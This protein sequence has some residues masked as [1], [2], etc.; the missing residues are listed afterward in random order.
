MTV[1]F[2]PGRAVPRS[3]CVGATVAAGSVRPRSRRECY[4]DAAR[5]AVVGVRQQREPQQQVRRE[6]EYL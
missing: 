2:D 6:V 4:A 5:T 3:G 1:N